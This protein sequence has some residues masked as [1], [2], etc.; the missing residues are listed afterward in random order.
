[1]NYDQQKWLDFARDAHEL[2]LKGQP[3]DPSLPTIQF[4]VEPS[5]ADSIFFQLAIKNNE[6]EWYRSTWHKSAD[7]PKITDPIDSLKY[8]GQIFRPA[9]TYENGTVARETVS[10]IID[11]ARSLSIRHD[12][13]KPGH[14]VLDGVRYMLKIGGSDAQMIFEWQILP[15]EW[16][17]LGELVVLLENLNNKL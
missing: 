15:E 6:V 12:I 2:L 5:F 11:Q 8:I 16:T 3:F 4:A 14:I 1:M 10:D 7:I 17:G 9:M 13:E